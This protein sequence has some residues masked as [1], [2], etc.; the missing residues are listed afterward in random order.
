MKVNFY[1]T[2][3]QI[4]G[5]KTIDIPLPGG[6]SVMD[7]VEIIVAQYPKMHSELLDESGRIYGHLHLFINGR[8]A[9]YLE[10]ALETIIQNEDKIDIFPAVG[11]G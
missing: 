8:D 10:N 4:I 3:R 9:S 11:G 7:L 5:Q 2:L 1:A 6:S